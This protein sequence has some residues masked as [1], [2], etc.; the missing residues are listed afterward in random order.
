MAASLE[1]LRQ[2]ERFVSADW[3]AVEYIVTFLDGAGRT[4]DASRFREL[5]TEGRRP[6]GFS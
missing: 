3:V 6:P 4:E 2:R 5:L 1:V